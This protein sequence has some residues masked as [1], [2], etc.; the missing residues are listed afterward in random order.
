M[1]AGKSSNLTITRATS[2]LFTGAAVLLH[3]RT[4]WRWFERYWRLKSEWIDD[5]R[6]A[7]GELWSEYKD[8]PAI[9]TASI[10][11]SDPTAPRDE[12]S[13]NT[14]E[15]LDQLGLYELEPC[16]EGLLAFE[17]PIP[18]WINKRNIWPQLA[19]MGLDIY[20]TPAMSDEPERVFSIAGNAL[21]PRRRC[22]TSDPCSGYYV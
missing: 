16:S 5:A 4:K 8:K 20:A 21:N 3:P 2:R 17:S 7:I 19:Q 9:S 22:L 1:L 13:N 12:W 10:G 11:S 6:T 18:Y 14:T 15:G